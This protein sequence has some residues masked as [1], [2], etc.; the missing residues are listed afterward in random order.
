MQRELRPAITSPPVPLSLE[1]EGVTPNVEFALED[2]AQFA[3]IQHFVLYPKNLEIESRQDQGPFF[4]PR[5]V[6][7]R[8]VARSV[9]FHDQPVLGAEEVHDEPE[10]DLLSAK[11]QAQHPT[12]T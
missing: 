7:E 9:D 10:V 6:F 4:I 5:L 2:G 3:L 11:L 12:I 8:L 1:G